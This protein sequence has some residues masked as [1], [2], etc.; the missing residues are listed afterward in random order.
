MYQQQPPPPQQQDFL[1]ADSRRRAHSRFPP[2]VGPS[3]GQ[4]PQYPSQGQGQM[5]QYPSQGQMPQYPSQGQ[6]QMLHASHGQGQLYQYPSQGQGQIALHPS[7]EQQ[8]GLQQQSPSS[9]PL[10]MDLSASYPS[11]SVSTSSM[12]AAFAP[13]LDYSYR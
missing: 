13:A 11:S 12:S 2:A 7:Q 8:L 3:Q 6:G 4:G 5:P 9:L 1:V 10:I